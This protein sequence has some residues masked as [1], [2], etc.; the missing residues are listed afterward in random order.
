MGCG[1]AGSG[2]AEVVA[3]E[4]GADG[5]LTG[6][7]VA[8]HHG[9]EERR[10]ASRTLGTV[11]VMLFLN[12]ADAADAA[13]DDGAHTVR[14]HVLEIRAGIFQRLNCRCHG[15]LCEPLHGADVLAVEV[16]RRIEVTD[17]TGN[18]DT[19]FGG[20]KAVDLGNTQ[21]SLLYIFPELFHSAAQRVDC[22]KSGDDYS[23]HSSPLSAAAVRQ[24]CFS[25]LRTC[26]HKRIQVPFRQILLHPA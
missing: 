23:F 4:A 21:C 10:D 18:A 7:H 25:I 12:S 9:Y 26:L 19:Q 14:I 24:A 2:G 6:S 16:F 11:L 1:G 22:A 20:V 3:A 13:A 8:D 15:N 17:D 5:N